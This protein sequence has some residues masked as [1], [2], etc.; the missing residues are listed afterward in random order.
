[1]VR[2]DSVLLMSTEPGS[3]PP[4][5]P[6]R[7]RRAW[8]VVGPLLSLVWLVFLSE[9]LTSIETGSTFVRVLTI[10]GVVGVAA[11]FAGTFFLIGVGRPQARALSPRWVVLVV[12][13]QLGFV[14]LS[15]LGAHEHGLVGL[16]FVSVTFL[17][18]VRTVVGL[19]GTVV[20]AA[21]ALVVPRLVPGWQAEDGT[22][23]AIVLASMA[24]FG[25]LQLIE[26]NRQLLVAQEQVAA[27]AVTRERDRIARDVHDVLGHSLTVVA[28]KSE[29]AS[30]LVTV[31]PQRAAAELRD[32]QALVRSAL[33]DVRGTVAAMH[34]VSLAA[35]LAAAGRALD[36][37][38][39]DA[40]LPTTV[41]MVP[42]DLREVFAWTV[43]EGTT[44]VLRHA[45]ASRVVVTLA[46]DRIVVE[47]DGQVEGRVRGQAGEQD[48]GHRAQVPAPA[49]TGS[50][51]PARG[52]GLSGLRER[53]AAVGAVLETGTGALGGFRLAVR[54]RAQ[55]PAPETR[56]T[57][58]AASGHRSAA[59]GD[60]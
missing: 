31:D 27:L 26:R 45:D 13:V 40:Q 32:I 22:V 58:R 59:T 20:L 39:I 35:E 49:R 42:E 23:W 34:Q 50:P 5:D 57:A 7:Q 53:A 51:G 48:R 37:A 25:F 12:L 16:V 36:A 52:H 38:G 6:R 2:D 41:D 8:R 9:P 17:Y 44:N 4:V 29:L 46:P 47:D 24:V 11:V 55:K 54:R 43:R 28:V 56:P 33:A 18:L 30:R 21:A 15:T 60:T 14:A 1:V 3:A 10:V 19:V